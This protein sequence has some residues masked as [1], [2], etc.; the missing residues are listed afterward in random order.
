MHGTLGARPR[1]RP[2]S[3]VWTITSEQLTTFWMRGGAMLFP[4]SGGWNCFRRRRHGL[5]ADGETDDTSSLTDRQ[6]D[7][8]GWWQWTRDSRVGGLLLLTTASLSA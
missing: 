8:L 1:S 2:M 7:T 5:L 3:S 4:G 6:M